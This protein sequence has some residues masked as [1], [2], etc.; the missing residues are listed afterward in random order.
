M[1]SMRDC[2][3]IWHEQAMNA[4]LDE[5]SLGLRRE[6]V[7]VLECAE[8]GHVGASLSLVEILRVLYDHILRY[9]P[10]RPDWPGRDRCILSKGHGC[11]P[12]YVMLAEKGF[13]PAEELSRFC[14]HGGLLGGHPDATKVPG[15]EAS[16]G[17]LG[18]GLS[19]GL[20]MAVSARM[21]NRDSRVFVILGDGEC[22][23]GSVWEA[24]M[25]AGVKG[26]DNL[27]LVVDYNK[28]Q[29]YDATC[30]VL[31][32]EPLA[33]KFVSFGWAVQEVNGHDV[34]ALR[35][36]FSRVPLEPGRP[37]AFICHTVKGKGVACAENNLEWHHKSRISC[38]QAQDL[39]RALA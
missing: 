8:R 3:K 35:E 22:N 7:R 32:L 39:Y 11:V 33:D 13:F 18:H 37:S 6:A 14:R 17:S 10:K 36:A 12:L 16:T 9:D 4:V 34:G 1:K 19:V 29:S 26:Q 27:S 21:D 2:A 28:Y 5:R 25:S 38:E 24:C 30:R 31:D 20:G 23:E 15:I